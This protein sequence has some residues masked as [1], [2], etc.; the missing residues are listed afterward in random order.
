M[1]DFLVSCHEGRELHR[2]KN[3]Q[4]IC[5]IL[6]QAENDNEEARRLRQILE[7]YGDKDKFSTWLYMHSYRELGDRL[8]PR[9]SRGRE[10]ITL[11]KRNLQ[12][13]IGALAQ[14][15]LAMGGKK[16]F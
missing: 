5:G 3:I 7:N 11:L 13:E 12:V 8:R 15:P 2:A 14:T 4:E 10:L 1:G 9:R 16:V 6:L